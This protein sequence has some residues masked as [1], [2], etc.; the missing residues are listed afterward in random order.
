[1]A[2][3]FFPLLA[4]AALPTVAWT[5]DVRRVVIVSVLVGLVLAFYMVSGFPP[6]IARAP[7]F[8]MAPGRRIQL[9]FSVLAL[10]LSVYLVSRCKA[11]IRAVPLWAGF[12]GCALFSDLVS[13]APE[14]A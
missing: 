10:L 8:S 1:M 14:D 4:I 3:S 13:L 2:P 12:S 7:G 9:G 11:P 6:E 5:R